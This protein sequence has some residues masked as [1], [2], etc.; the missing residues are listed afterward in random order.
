[1]S[2]S[3]CVRKCATTTAKSGVVAL[4]IEATPLAICVWAKTMRLKGKTLLS[5]PDT[6]NM[7]KARR[8]VGMATPTMRTIRRS[9]SAASATRATTMVKSG[10]SLIAT[11][12]KK[13][14]PP[15][16]IDSASS[17]AHSS[18][19]MA[20]LIR[21]LPLSGPGIL[22]PLLPGQ[23]HTLI[24]PTGPANPDSAPADSGPR[25]GRAETGRLSRRCESR[26]R[27]R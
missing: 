1:M 20:L 15:H 24:L 25:L 11:P 23:S 4:R 3:S 19:D 5:T 16:S 13:N 22:V 14:E 18:D 8:S 9:A 26:H 21:G 10:T 2:F 6:A 27:H 17:I 12:T 7:P